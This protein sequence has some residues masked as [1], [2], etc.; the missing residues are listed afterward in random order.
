MNLRFLILGDGIYTGRIEFFWRPEQQSFCRVF[1][2]CP[3]T[4]DTGLYIGR[5]LGKEKNKKQ[6]KKGSFLVLV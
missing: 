1:C 2:G 5:Y 3:T 4:F 6:K